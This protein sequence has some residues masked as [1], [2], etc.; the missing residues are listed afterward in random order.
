M[1]NIPNSLCGGGWG[2]GTSKSYIT[3]NGD[4]TANTI[5]TLS[6]SNIGTIN[7]TSIGTLANSSIGVIN[8]YIN[9]GNV[10]SVSSSYNVTMYDYYIG[11]NSNGSGNVTVTM[12]PGSSLQTGKLYFIKDESGR[13]SIQGYRPIIQMSGGDL[14]DMNSTVTMALNNIALQIIWT[15]TRWSIV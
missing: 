1:D 6:T 5:S 13:A 12:P 2:G 7:T 15:G 10:V 3:L 11:V 8:Q 4:L 9:T 14:L